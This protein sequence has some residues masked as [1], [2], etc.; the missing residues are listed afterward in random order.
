ME[1][2]R[3]DEAAFAGLDDAVVVQNEVA[4][5]LLDELGLAP[6]LAVIGG[7]AHVGR[8]SIQLFLM[9]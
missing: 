3:D 9:Q 5:G 4:G 6:G 2:E 8:Q 1:S 7:E